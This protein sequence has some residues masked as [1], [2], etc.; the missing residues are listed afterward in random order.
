MNDIPACICA[1]I[2]APVHSNCVYGKLLDCSIRS[3]AV[4]E[5][6]AR[7]AIPP[8]DFHALSPVACLTVVIFWIKCTKEV[9]CMSDPYLWHLHPD[10]AF[11]NHW[12]FFFFFFR[13]LVGLAQL[14]K[15]EQ[16]GFRCW[17][18]R[19]DKPT[20]WCFIECVVTGWCYS[21]DFRPSGG[22]V[23]SRSRCSAYVLCI[24]E[25]CTVR[26]HQHNIIKPYYLIYLQGNLI[27]L[28]EDIFIVV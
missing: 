20:L 22:V 5:P 13:L 10:S 28:W 24:N 11:F 6:L 27:T 21:N 1:L 17:E 12:I 14:S 25:K 15:R 8:L 26:M 23:C 18:R 16:N 7:I 2:L 19:H 4:S 9:A 3:K